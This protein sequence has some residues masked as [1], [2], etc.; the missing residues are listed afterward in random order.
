MVRMVRLKFF[1]LF[2][3][4]LNNQNSFR[5]QNSE[6]YSWTMSIKHKYLKK[7]KRNWFHR[8]NRAVLKKKNLSRQF[9]SDDTTDLHGRLFFCLPIPK[10]KWKKLFIIFGLDARTWMHMKM[11]YVHGNNWK[12]I[13]D[14]TW[15]YMKHM[16]DTWIIQKRTMS[17]K[18]N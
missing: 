2:N 8:N 17:E 6:F 7:K 16:C 18:K 12:S 14:T 1:D 15:I 3:R 11:Y 10:K 13:L 5:I 9:V 4:L